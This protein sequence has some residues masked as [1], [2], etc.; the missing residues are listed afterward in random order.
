MQDLSSAPLDDVSRLITVKINPDGTQPFEIRRANSL[1][2]HIWNLYGLVL[3]A[4]IGDRVGVDLWNYEIHRT[5]IRK[6][7]DFVLPYALEKQSWPYGQIEPL[8]EDDLSFLQGIVCQAILHY[9]NQS[10]LQAYRSLD[11]KNLRT[12]YQDTICNLHIKYMRPD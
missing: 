11:T 2:Y 5:S 6:A 8:E 1:H 10:Y 7:L 9:N 4:R 12:H 3:L